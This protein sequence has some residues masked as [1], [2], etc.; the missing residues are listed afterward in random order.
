M[1][2]TKKETERQLKDMR[3]TL[4]EFLTDLA[5]N[6]FNTPDGRSDVGFVKA[7]FSVLSDQKIMDNMVDNLL[8]Y[9]SEIENRNLNFFVKEKNKIFSGLPQEKI[10]HFEFLI[11]TPA[12]KGGLTDSNRGVIWDYFQ[13]MLDIAKQFKKIH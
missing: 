3:E 8:P 13:V 7:F 1:S 2:K 6:I 4:M 10:D 5:D 11:I 9:S 12:D